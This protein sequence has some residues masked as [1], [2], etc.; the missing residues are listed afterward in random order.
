MEISGCKVL[1]A[2]VSVIYKMPLDLHQFSKTKNRTLPENLVVSGRVE[3]SG[4][5]SNHYWRDLKIMLLKIEGL[6]HND[7]TTF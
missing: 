3:P 4:E 1:I 7:S 6:R 2:P 5:I